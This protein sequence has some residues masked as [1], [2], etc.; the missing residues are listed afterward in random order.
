MFATVPNA[1]KIAFIHLGKY[2]QNLGY[3]WID[4][5]QDTAHLRSM[6]AKLVSQDAFLEL[7]RKNQQAIL[8]SPPSNR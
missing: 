3:E 7:L 4:C 8:H 1:S 2:L 6:G 5:Q